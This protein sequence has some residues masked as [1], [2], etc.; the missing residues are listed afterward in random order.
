MASSAKSQRPSQPKH[1]RPSSA[2]E[3]ALPHQTPTSV[4]P[5]EPPAEPHHGQAAGN[6]HQSQ[7]RALHSNSESKQNE[8]HPETPAG[9]HAT[10]SF[11][12][13]SNERSGSR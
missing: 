6:T 2:A 11:T 10:G 7:R 12:D 9:Q 3:G 8:Q 1:Q 13:D 4:T 5:V